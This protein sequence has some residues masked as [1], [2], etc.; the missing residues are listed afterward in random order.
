M[1]TERDRAKDVFVLV[2]R[3]SALASIVWYGPM[4]PS[5][6]ENYLKWTETMDIMGVRI[7][8]LADMWGAAALNL[9]RKD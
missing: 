2:Q 6:A 9:Q 8:S 4:E 1:S 3:T 5:E 7:I